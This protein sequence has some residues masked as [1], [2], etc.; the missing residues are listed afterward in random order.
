MAPKLSARRGSS[1][2]V[3]DAYM[4]CLCSIHHLSLTHT[5][6]HSQRL[7]SVSFWQVEEDR[8]KEML[9]RSDSENIASSYFKSKRASQL[10]G[11]EATKGH[12]KTIE[13]ASKS[14]LISSLAE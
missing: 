10:L 11:L 4:V 14:W 5:L 2:D 6:K 12:G 8:Y 7:T 13:S 3:G 9:D 1:V